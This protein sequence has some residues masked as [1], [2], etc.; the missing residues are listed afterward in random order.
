MLSKL[1]CSIGWCPLLSL[2]LF[3]CV[4]AWYL[5]PSCNTFPGFVGSVTNAF[6]FAA[7]TVDLYDRNNPYVIELGDL[8]APGGQAKELV[9]ERSWLRLGSTTK[10]VW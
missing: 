5:H 6:A 4:H 9:G 2:L 7:K 10:N 8:I 1:K 3:D